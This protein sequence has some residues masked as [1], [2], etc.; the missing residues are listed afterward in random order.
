ME[1]VARLDNPSFIISIAGALETKVGFVISNGIVV[2]HGL[3]FR[4]RLCGNASRSVD[5]R[6]RSNK[7]PTAW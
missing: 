5:P 1:Q 2:R 4:F 6:G 3:C 7:P